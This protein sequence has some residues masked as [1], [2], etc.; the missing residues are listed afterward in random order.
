MPTKELR[1]VLLIDDDDSLRRVTEYSLHS[2]GFEVKSAADGKQGLI[3]FHKDRPQVVITDIQ[4]P[5]LS[6]LEVLKQI[7]AERPETIVIVI[8]AYSSIEKAVAAM[9]DGAYDY[10]EKPFSRDELVLMV[11]RAFSLLELQQESR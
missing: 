2:A 11:E 6:G 8:T 3:S 1:K 10:M 9:K 5:G 4:M 7:K